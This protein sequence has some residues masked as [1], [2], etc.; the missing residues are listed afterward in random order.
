MDNRMRT[1]LIAVGAAVVAFTAGALWQN[2]SARGYA[3]RLDVTQRDL[4]YQRL[5]AT[6]GA[7]T[8]EAQR[9]SYE[10]ARQ[11]AS[12]FFTELQAELATASAEPPPAFQEILASRDAMITALSRADAQSG[13]MLAR[14]FLRYRLALGEPVGPEPAA[15]SPPVSTTGDP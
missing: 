10:L 7:A 8:I 3:E 1:I 4:T 2:A 14:L 9:G 13:S 11:L 12:E 5:E 6:L 15:S